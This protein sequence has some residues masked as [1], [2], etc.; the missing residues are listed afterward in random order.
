MTEADGRFFMAQPFHCVLRALSCA[1]REGSK[2]R[3]THPSLTA[4][5]YED[6]SPA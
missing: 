1:R 5:D 6:L 4:S 2:S 3:I